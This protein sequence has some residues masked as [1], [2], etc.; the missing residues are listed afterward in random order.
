MSA[1]NKRKAKDKAFYIK[2][3]KQART[4]QHEL[5]VGMKGFLCTSNRE[6]ESVREAYNILNE[7]ADILYGSD[8]SKNDKDDKNDE[9]E[10]KDEKGNLEI[11]DE[12]SKEVAEMKKKT[13]PGERRFQSVA[14]GV[15]G[16]LFIRS[17]VSSKDF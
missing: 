15:K 1:T 9:S 3:A 12:L 5:G 7:F 4:S 8:K 17:T 6:K 14:T 10:K 13:T 16:C 11:E 2:S